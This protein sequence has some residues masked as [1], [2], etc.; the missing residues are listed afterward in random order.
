MGIRVLAS[1]Y[2]PP[3]PMAT[4]RSESKPLHHFPSVATRGHSP[5]PSLLNPSL[6]APVSSLLGLH[7][8]YTCSCVQ[9]TAASSHALDSTFGSNFCQM[10]S[11]PLAAQPRSQRGTPV[12]YCAP[13]SAPLH[14]ASPTT[15]VVCPRSPL[16]RPG[17]LGA[18]THRPGHEVLQGHLCRVGLCPWSLPATVMVAPP[19]WI[20]SVPSTSW[21]ALLRAPPVIL[22]FSCINSFPGDFIHLCHFHRCPAA[23]VLHSPI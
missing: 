1:P 6:R 21:P 20:F 23:W 9:A 12:T 13:L 17:V 14:P 15:H 3:P 18:G 22:S 16:P 8:L 4:D 7:L 5:P 11:L 10:V 2:P 19:V